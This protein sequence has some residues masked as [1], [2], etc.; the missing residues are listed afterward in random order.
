[1]FFL[2]EIKFFVSCIYLCIRATCGGKGFQYIP[3]H[4]Q[5]HFERN[6]PAGKYWFQRHSPPTFPARP[7]KILFE[8]LGD[9]L[10]WRPRDVPIWRPGDVLKWRPW[11]VL[12][13]RSRDVPGRL[14][15]DVPRTFSG[16]PLEDLQSTQTWISQIFFNF[17]FRTDSIDQ[18]YLKA[19]QCSR[20]IE[21]PMKLLR[22][23]I[24]CKISY[25]IFSR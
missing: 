21:N 13:W 6:Y 14:I 3:V 1:M 4:G 7:L 12:I 18:I 20:C 10:I 11:D 25:W 8:R 17:S 9:V 2:S 15:R 5:G 16:H 22:W 19:F 23:S 24:F